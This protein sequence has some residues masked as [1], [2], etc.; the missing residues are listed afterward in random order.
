MY[1]G[2]SGNW[3]KTIILAVCLSASPLT[4]YA[5]E[6]YQDSADTTYTQAELSQILAPIALYPDALLA[7]IL[8]A[9]TYP[10]E[11]VE[12]QRWLD[13]PQ[14]AALRGDQLA[15]ALNQQKWDPSVK[16]L[17]PFPQVISML[18]KN[19]EW[20]EALGDAFMDDEDMVMDTVQQ[21]RAQ[22]QAAGTLN[23]SGQ[24]N[25]SVIDREIIIEPVNPQTIYIPYYNPSIVYG[26]WVYPDY[27]PYYFQQPR[28]VVY[29]NSFVGFG[30]GI[31]VI[32]TYWGWN[33]WDWNRR[34]I[35]IDNDRY[36]RINHN[37]PPVSVDI[38]RHDPS[39]RH[40]VPYHQNKVHRPEN[41]TKNPEEHFAKPRRNPEHFNNQPMTQSSK[42]PPVIY[43]SPRKT[44]TP[45]IP[46]PAA[47]Q[48]TPPAPPQAASPVPAVNT[49]P[50]D[51]TNPTRENRQHHSRR[52]FQAN[53][54]N[55]QPRPAT[56]PEAVNP[57]NIVEGNRRH[58]GERHGRGTRNN[59]GDNSHKD[60]NPN[61]NSPKMQK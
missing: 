22:A 35:Y 46:Q 38:W 61:D 47:P 53:P 48:P 6:T 34:R 30:S 55:I 14:N 32:P 60:N 17:V 42:T 19:L 12:A 7:Q 43:E 3:L 56:N 59:D 16:S 29:S 51:N 20:T 15:A 26:N 1:R 11:V 24:Q 5:Q 28:G 23:S 18:D 52:I 41:F 2:S 4:V 49:A 9:A 25:I 50:T 39:H 45:E 40:G 31:T 37:R 58:D 21:L 8:M 54:E 27:P 57:K 10:L 13:N 33:R 44:A 36:R